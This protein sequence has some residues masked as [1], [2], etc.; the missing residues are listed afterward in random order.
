MKLAALELQ[1]SRRLAS[2]VVSPRA[3][4]LMEQEC[5]GKRMEKKSC[6]EEPPNSPNVNRIGEASHFLSQSSDRGNY[7]LTP[8]I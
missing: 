5:E 1:T 7:D 6:I 8:L 4:D 3:Q 2:V